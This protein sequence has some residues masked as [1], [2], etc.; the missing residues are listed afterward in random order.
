MLVQDGERTLVTRLSA[1]A[2]YARSH[3]DSAPVRAAVDAARIVYSAGFFLTNAADVMLDCGK[4]ASA[5]GGTSIYAFNLSAPFLCQFFKEQMHAVLPFA[6]VVFGNEAEGRQLPSRR[7]MAL[8]GRVLQ[9]RHSASPTG[10]R[11]V[12]GGAVLW[13]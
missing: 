5:S 3:F 10:A 13:C 6:D 1:A 12:G 4:A 9:R 8:L 2:V 7:P 11:K